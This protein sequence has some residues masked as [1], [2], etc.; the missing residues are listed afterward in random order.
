MYISVV[1]IFGV[2]FA[3]N[4]KRRNALLRNIGDIYFIFLIPVDISQRFVVSVLS[5]QSEEA[6]NFKQLLKRNK[7]QSRLKAGLHFAQYAAA[8]RMGYESA[9]FVLAH[10][11]NF[12]VSRGKQRYEFP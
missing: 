6:D 11:V 9:H 3:F 10:F 8:Y 12:A 7:R 2:Y 1:C 4:R 5:H